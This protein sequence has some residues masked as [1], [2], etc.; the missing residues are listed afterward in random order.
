MERLQSMLRAYN[1]T[2]EEDFLVAPW[3]K[4][5]C[6]DSFPKYWE[7]VY[8]ILKPLNKDNRILEVGSGLGDITA[9]LCYLDFTNIIAFEKDEQICHIA[10]RRLKDMFNRENIVYNEKFPNRQNYSSDVLVLVNCAYADVAKS[11]EEYLSLLKEYYICAGKPQYYLMEV[12]DSSYTKTDKEFPE[13]IRLNYDEVRN[14][15]PCSTIMSWETY[16]YPINRKSKTLY[17][18]IKD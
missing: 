10:Q 12:I 14:L 5:Y 4:Q 2:H 7:L 15:F 9:I 18:I 17:L 3:S 11:K 6:E 16:K 8:S 13:Y 1:I